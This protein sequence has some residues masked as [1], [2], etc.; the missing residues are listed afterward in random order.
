MK[1]LFMLITIPI[2]LGCAQGEGNFKVKMTDAPIDD[3]LGKVVEQVNVTITEINVRTKDQNADNPK[4]VV[5]SEVQ[6]INLIDLLNGASTTIAESDL[7]AGE[8]SEI[9]VV[10]DSDANTIKFE[11]DETLYELKIPSGADSGVK[12]KT[13]FTVEE[14]KDTEILLDFD[15]AESIVVKGDGTYGFEPVIKIKE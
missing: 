8:Y 7:D 3:K 15:A 10:L 2:M 4:P 6:T 9:R 11:N 14:G 13:S 12:I 1:N 5:S